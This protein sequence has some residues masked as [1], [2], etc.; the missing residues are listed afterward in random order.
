MNRIGHRRIKPKGMSVLNY[1]DKGES[2][3]IS[4]N[5]FPQGDD[6]DAEGMDPTL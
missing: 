6:M 3:H 4:F 2:V 5:A 1:F